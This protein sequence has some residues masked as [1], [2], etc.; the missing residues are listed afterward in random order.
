M[1]TH[2]K[3]GDV[4]IT[5]GFPVDEYQQHEPNDHTAEDRQR[6]QPRRQN[7]A[8]GNGPEEEG[9]IQRFF[10]GGAEADDGQRAHHAQ[11]QHH[12]AGDAAARIYG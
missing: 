2:K 4:G 10:D 9:N 7:D 1:S 3:H 12:V 5:A 8:H 6:N 11:G